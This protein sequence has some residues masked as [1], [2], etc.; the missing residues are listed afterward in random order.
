[1]STRISEERNIT[2]TH[3]TR[4]RISLFDFIMT[5]IEYHFL[6][7]ALPI[8]EL[9]NYIFVPMGGIVKKEGPIIF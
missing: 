6:M 3:F 7:G 1:M 2:Q 8:H 4:L 9:I 5:D